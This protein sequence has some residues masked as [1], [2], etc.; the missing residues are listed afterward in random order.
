MLFGKFFS[1]E[2][3]SEN[4]NINPMKILVY[5]KEQLTNVPRFLTVAINYVRT[6][7]FEEDPDYQ[8]IIRIF[9][10]LL[11]EQRNLDDDNEEDE[12]N[13]EGLEDEYEWS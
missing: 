4:P 6:L 8:Y 12:E 9:T 11:S 1:L 2:P 10:E 13:N 7:K 3:P 5:K